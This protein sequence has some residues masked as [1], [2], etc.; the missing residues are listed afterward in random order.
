MWRTRLWEKKEAAQRTRSWFERRSAAVHSASL[1][2][3]SFTE[4]LDGRRHLLLTDA[5]VLLS[6]G[7]SLE[8]LPGE[9]AQ[10]EVHEDV[11][12]GLQ[13]IASG[14]LCGQ[15]ARRRQHKRQ[16]TVL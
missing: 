3:V 13:V 9:G 11:A 16:V 4:D 8:A 12:E 1:T 14:L 15:T 6:L 10:V 7:R 2:R 5:L